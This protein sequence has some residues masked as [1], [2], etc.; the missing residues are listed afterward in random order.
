MTDW[1]LADDDGADSYYQQGLYF[2]QKFNKIQNEDSNSKAIKWLNLANSLTSTDDPEK[3]TRLIA[4]GKAFHDRFEWFGHIEDVN[5]AISSLEEALTLLPLLHEQKPFVLGCLGWYYRSRFHR[6]DSLSDLEKAVIFFSDAVDLAPSGKSVQLSTMANLG[7]TLQFRYQ[8]LKNANDIDLSI[9][10]I[11][12]ALELTKDNT[13]AKVSRLEALGSAY[14]RKYEN[15]GHMADLISAIEHHSN[16]TNLTSD[17]DPAKPNRH[18][19]LALVLQQ[20]FEREMN[21][22]DLDSSIVHGMLAVKLTPDGH[23]EKSQ[24]LDNLGV[25]ILSRAITL[26]NFHDF[27][28]AIK[29]MSQAVELTPE[30]HPCLSERLNNLENAFHARYKVVKN[31]DDLNLAIITTQKAVAASLKT[32]S[33]KALYLSNLSVSMYERFLRQKNYSDL[34]AAIANMSKSVNLTPDNHPKK[35]VRLT[36]YGNALLSQYQVSYLV[37]DLNLAI[38]TLLKGIELIPDMHIER[39]SSLQAVAVAYRIKYDKFKTST[40]LSLAIKYYSASAQQAVGSISVKFESAR[41]WIQLAHIKIDGTKDSSLMQACYCALNLLPQ[42]A[43]L[44]F[45]VQQ[46]FKELS[47]IPRVTGAIFACAIEAENFHLALE[48]LEQGRSIV[49]VQ[50]LQLRTPLDM[51][52]LEHPVLAKQLA[53]ISKILEYG[54]SVSTIS[55]I[56]AES[57]EMTA[58]RYRKTVQKWNELLSSIRLLHGF[59]QFLLPKPYS[60]LCTAARY[61]PVIVLSASEYH[62]DALI[63]KS[64]ESIQHISLKDIN[65]S[66]LVEL[67]GKLSSQQGGRQFRDDHYRHFKPPVV[68]QVDPLKAVLKALWNKVVKPVISALEIQKSDEPVRLWWCPTGPFA[69]LPLHAAGIQEDGD[70]AMDYVISSYLTSLSHLIP[71]HHSSINNSFQFLALSQGATPGASALPATVKEIEV[72]RTVVPSHNLITLKG[73]DATVNETLAHLAN[74]SWCHFACHGKQDSSTPLDSAFLLH[75]GH[76]KLSTIMKAN[77]PNAEFAFLSACQTATG[78]EKLPDEATH[79]AAGL[80]HAGFKSVV[81]TLWP[82]A[83]QDGPIIAKEMYEKLFEGSRRP[84]PTQAAIALHNA[85]W[86][87]RRSGV[88]SSRWVPFIHIGI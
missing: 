75:D 62:C 44:G 84:D 49:W 50:L 77:L 12:Q 52:Q 33:E 4:L 9:A 63:M 86:K 14:W 21:L 81:A 78:D 76:L 56:S 30:N 16:T 67:H 25:S 43:W 65:E 53:E 66:D 15:L 7:E 19:N 64:P 71:Q 57:Q 26:K 79:L 46:R 40:D 85:I 45:D 20:K 31:L 58:Q 41:Q 68:K 42:I 38:N 27:E 35:S 83:D 69:S 70:T 60:A 2:S 3:V 11:T 61:G 39:A 18:N 1:M 36:N 8:K 54:N 59:E 22:T 37:D 32:D 6:C 34:V 51:L 5:S 88:P 72:I 17:N 48:W 73:S 29:N 28:V 80:I 13:S 87:L 23:L 10:K 74:T 82:I 24:R 55:A 47:E